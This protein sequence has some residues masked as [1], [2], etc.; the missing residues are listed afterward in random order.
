MEEVGSTRSVEKTGPALRAARFQDARVCK[1]VPVALEELFR[2]APL[3]PVKRDQNA[4][5]CR[6]TGSRQAR[7][8]YRQIRR[9]IGS[10]VVRK[11]D[12]TTATRRSNRVLEDRFAGQERGANR[13][14]Q[15]D[16]DGD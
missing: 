11:S 5:E 1:Q 6:P 14:H 13:T 3:R 9:C 2:P 7:R 12:H 10:R 15:G 8:R 4:G 16:I